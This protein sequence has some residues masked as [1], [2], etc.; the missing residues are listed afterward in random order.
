[1]KIACFVEAYNFKDKSEISALSKF[2]S[3]AELMGHT[4]EFIFKDDI[5]K[6]PNYD[7][8]FIRAITDPSNSAY[9]VSRL[10]E[11][12]GLKVIDDPHSIRTCSN[13]A[14][15]H[16]MFLKNNMPAPKSFLFTGDYSDETFDDIKKTLGLPVV[17]KTPYT[18]FSSHVEKADNKEEFIKISKRLL[19]KTRVLVL[20]EYIRSSFDWRV[21]ILRNEVLYS[22][23]YCIPKGGWKVKSK[24]NGKNV[25]GDTIAIS[26]DS[27]SPELKEIC[28]KL[29]KCVGDGLYGLDVKET[30]GG[31]KV[32]EINDNP[33][34]YEGYEDAVDKDI[35]EKIIN[36]L[37]S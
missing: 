9:I 23:K 28:I 32:I 26:R 22:C 34:I 1:M 4:F 18:R 21:G 11:Q 37:V 31:Y 12:Y 8:L 27:I 14:I 29:S 6:I 17:I 15:L 16:D 13:K 10:A 33:S 7:A 19:R 3:T 5:S 20:Q 36:A 30:E 25:W 24:I 2:K 35:Y